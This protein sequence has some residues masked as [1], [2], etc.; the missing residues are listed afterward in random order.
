MTYTHPAKYVYTSPTKHLAGYLLYRKSAIDP[1]MKI[2]DSAA[3]KYNFQ[4][5][6][7]ALPYFS[8]R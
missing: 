6:R 7:I 1:P 4:S 5:S 2:R 8:T 3:E